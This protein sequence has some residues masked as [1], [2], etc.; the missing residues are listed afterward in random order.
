MNRTEHI[1]E[2]KKDFLVSGVTDW[3]MLVEAQS[4]ARYY[5]GSDDWRAW[6]D[7]SMEFLAEL[8]R[9]GLTIPGDFTDDRGFR[10]WDLPTEDALA[11][12]RDEWSSFGAE[13][14]MGDVCW[15]DVTPA[16][17]ELG[18]VYEAEEAG[19]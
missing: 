10:P 9:D 14:D 8:M 19:N 11:R 17:R 7:F 5:T 3:V 2:A 4:L 12:I 6:R 15:F 18:E 13:L 1:E 16:G